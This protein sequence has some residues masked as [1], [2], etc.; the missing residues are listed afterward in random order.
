MWGGLHHTFAKMEKK[1]WPPQSG[2][3]TQA[4][5]GTTCS[6]ACGIKEVSDALEQDCIQVLFL[7]EGE[8]LK[9]ETLVPR[10]EAVG[11][12]RHVVAPAHPLSDEVGRHGP[13]RMGVLP[14]ST[15]LW[16]MR[17]LH[18]RSSWKRNDW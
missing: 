7:A 14:S 2:P 5:E 4:V 6:V 1:V 3:F 17:L 18:P 8:F 12:T 10:M 15:N 11:F 9:V 13:C 16:L